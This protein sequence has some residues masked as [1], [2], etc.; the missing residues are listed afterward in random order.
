MGFFNFISEMFSDT[1]RDD[2]GYERYK[3]S[4]KSVHRYMAEKK[5]GRK[6]RD[7]EVV[8]HKDRNKTNNSKDNLWV[9]KNQAEHDRVH[10]QDARQHGKSA[11]YQGFKKKKKGGFWDLF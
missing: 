1:Y 7:G 10:K 5:L 2:K 4:G 9:F 8:H 3:D 11:S 6:L